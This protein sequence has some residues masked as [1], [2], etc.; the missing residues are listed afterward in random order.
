MLSVEW[1]CHP[2]Q[3]GTWCDCKRQYDL[4]TS[5]SRR[6]SAHTHRGILCQ[7]LGVVV[8]NEETIGPLCLRLDLPDTPI[9]TP[10]SK[11]TGFLKTK[12]SSLCLLI[13]FSWNWHCIRLVIALWFLPQPR[14]PSELMEER[15]SPELSFG[16]EALEKR[17]EVEGGKLL[18]NLL[19]TWHPKRQALRLMFIGMFGPSV[20]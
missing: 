5:P 10:A 1:L 9:P 4:V 13:H 7:T 18:L 16:T 15:K 6:S 8:Q 19:E 3:H 12:S 2:T 11:L 17:S 20:C 14:N